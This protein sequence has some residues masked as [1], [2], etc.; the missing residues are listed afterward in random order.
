MILGNFIEAPAGIRNCFFPVETSTGGTG[1]GSNFTS[2]QLKLL[3]THFFAEFW[4]C[5]KSPA[6]KAQ[7]GKHLLCEMAPERLFSTCT[8]G[9]S[10]T[11][12]LAV[13]PLYTPICWNNPRI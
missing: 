10:E 5:T 9:S 6:T 1:S 7:K 2:W 13:V 3:L 4:C 11:T 12:E 8:F